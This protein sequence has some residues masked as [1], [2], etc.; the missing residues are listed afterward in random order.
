MKKLKNKLR[1]FNKVL[2][3]MLDPEE[4]KYYERK[5]NF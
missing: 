5:S 1:S 2:G 4:E 3:D